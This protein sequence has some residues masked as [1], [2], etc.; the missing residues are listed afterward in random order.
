MAVEDQV[1]VIYVAGQGLLDKMPVEK[2]R[3]FQTEL[4]S[5]LHMKHQKVLNSIAE[6][7]QMSDEAAEMIKKEAQDLAS[8][9]AD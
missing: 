4:L 7:G 6:S 9:Y 5:R 3:E 8:V 1:A 2:V